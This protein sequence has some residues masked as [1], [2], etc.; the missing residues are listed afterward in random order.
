[1]QQSLSADNQQITDTDIA[2]LAGI[3]DAEGS[4]GLYKNGNGNYYARVTITN[5]DIRMFDKI[6]NILEKLHLSVYIKENERQK[7]RNWKPRWQMVFSGSTKPK[8]FLNTLMPYLV[9]KK[10]EAKLTLEFIESRS[11]KR[12]Q[13]REGSLWSKAPLT[14]REQ[15]LVD[16]VKNLK[17]VRHLR[18]Y[19]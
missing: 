15:S 17:Q 14:K 3:M 11:I 12:Y 19:T 8:K 18:D 5:T 2:W 7:G 6:K 10:L 13:N 16:E 9:T 4:I 1:M